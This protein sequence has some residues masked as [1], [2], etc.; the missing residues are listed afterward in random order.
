[1]KWATPGAGANW[2]LLN[3]GGTALTAAQ[4]I[5]VSGISG[6]DKIMVLFTGASQTNNDTS[7]IS[8]R[9]N[10]LSTSIY[11]SGG[12]KINGAASY[13]ASI[14]DCI[15]DFGASAVQVCRTGNTGSSTASGGITFTGCNSAG[16]KQF[17]FSAGVTGGDDKQV[18]S[19]Q[20]YVDTS[21]SITSISMRSLDSN[22]DAGT[23]Y[24]YTSA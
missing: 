14:F 12:F 11:Y 9:L 19:G 4:I 23:V 13:G 20:G 21:A 8:V 22:F 10:T 15:T 5:T 16:V 24:V 6:K 18:M 17:I 7:Q 2:S 1:L 3:S